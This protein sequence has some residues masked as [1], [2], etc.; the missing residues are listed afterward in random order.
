MKITKKIIKV[1]VELDDIE[2]ATLEEAVKVLQ[3][4]KETMEIYDCDILECCCEYTYDFSEVEDTINTLEKFE[5]ISEI[6]C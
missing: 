3:Q 2:R 6:T 1:N 4:I 5:S